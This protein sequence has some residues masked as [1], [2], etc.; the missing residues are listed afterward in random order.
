MNEINCLSRWK[1][2]HFMTRNPRSTEHNWAKTV[3]PSPWSVD[4]KAGTAWR[5][6]TTHND[7][8][9]NPRLCSRVRWI[10]VAVK[11]RSLLQQPVSKIFKF[12]LKWWIL[13]RNLLADGWG[14]GEEMKSPSFYPHLEQPPS[15]P[16][17]LHFCLFLLTAA[18]V[19]TGL[20]GLNGSA[21]SKVVLR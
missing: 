20:M 15:P 17:H 13:A 1:G 2:W 18:P 11:Q 14:W 21:S 10:H 6:C 16:R 9:M 7:K 12:V 19:A 5:F 4:C 8:W 3:H